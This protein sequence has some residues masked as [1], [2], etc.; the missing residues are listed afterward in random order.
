MHNGH[1]SKS[2]IQIEC[3]KLAKSLQSQPHTDL[4]TRAQ[5]ITGHVPAMLW[6]QLKIAR[7]S[8]CVPE[9]PY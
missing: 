8:K 1:V 6:V 4:T 5:S 2:R 9:F 3:L 7:S